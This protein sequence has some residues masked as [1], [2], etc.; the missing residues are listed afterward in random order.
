MRVL[1]IAQVFWRDAVLYT[2]AEGIDWF[3]KEGS[4]VDFVTVG[5]VIKM[6]R[7]EVVL[8]HEIND[9]DEARSTS[10][11]PRNVITRIEYLKVEERLKR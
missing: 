3:K 7:K 9:G 5:H 2:G 10:V 4:T 1:K 8:A 11:I 6:G